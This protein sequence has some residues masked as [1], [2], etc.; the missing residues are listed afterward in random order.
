[1]NL[2][3]AIT[4]GRV[5]KIEVNHYFALFAGD[6]LLLVYLDILDLLGIGTR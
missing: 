5:W 2:D 4:D 3:P 1:M 6:Q